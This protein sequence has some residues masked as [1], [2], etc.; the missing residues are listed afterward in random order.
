MFYWICSTIINGKHGLMESPRKTFTFY[1]S[2]EGWFR[3]LTQR[4]VHGIIPQAFARR[5]LVSTSMVVLL[6]LRKIL[7]RQNSGSPSV[8]S[9]ICLLRGRLRAGRRMSSPSVTQFPLQFIYFTLHV[10][11]IL[12]MGDM[13]FPSRL[14]FTGISCMLT[15]F[16]TSSPFEASM[17]TAMLGSPWFY[18]L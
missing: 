8:T 2:C 1:V 6:V 18:L 13:A 3:Y 10:S 5:A 15:S 11:I 17:R 16:T 12:C 4:L 7:A 9:T 14:I